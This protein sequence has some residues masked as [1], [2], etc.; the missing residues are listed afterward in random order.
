MYLCI[1]YVLELYL[2]LNIHKSSYCYPHK[3]S[4]IYTLSKLGR[5]KFFVNKKNVVLVILKHC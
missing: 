2:I 3:F 1:E 4:S 5:Y